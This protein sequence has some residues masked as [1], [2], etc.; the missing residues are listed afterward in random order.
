MSMYTWSSDD[1]SSLKPRDLQHAPVHVSQVRWPDSILCIAHEH[2][3]QGRQ[4]ILAVHLPSH[5]LLAE[6]SL[7]DCHASSCNPF[8]QLLFSGEWPSISK[9]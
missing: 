3:R 9:A 7:L 8:R 6:Q 1:G 5:N 4:K 2:R